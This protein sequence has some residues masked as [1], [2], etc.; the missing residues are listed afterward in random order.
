MDLVEVREYRRDPSENVNP[1]IRPSR[2]AQSN[3][4]PAAV[5]L[6]YVRIRTGSRSAADSA[7][8][9]GPKRRLGPYPTINALV[10]AAQN[11][12]MLKVQPSP[13]TN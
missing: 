10:S 12:D 4:S 5:R 13:Y 11:G 2:T 9:S 1:R 6:I 8:E 7:G 3:Q